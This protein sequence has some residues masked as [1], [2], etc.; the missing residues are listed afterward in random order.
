MFDDAKLN[1]ALRDWDVEPCGSRVT[2]DPAP[3]NT[4]R[5]FLVTLKSVT[6][7]DAA[8]ADVVGALSDLGFVWEGSQHYQDMIGNYFMSFRK[9]DMNLIVTASLDFARRH[10]AATHVC[11]RLNLL[12]KKDRVALFQAVLY[13]E[14]YF[15]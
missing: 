6:R 12:E 15:E 13:G 8:I 1:E 11:K 2:C 10:R 7:A 14:R 4:D 3:V 9:G 5:D